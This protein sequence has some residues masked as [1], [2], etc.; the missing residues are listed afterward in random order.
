MLP[1]PMDIRLRTHD[2]T[3]ALHLLGLRYEPGGHAFIGIFVFKSNGYGAKLA[4]WMHV[5]EIRKLID[6]LRAMDTL[7]QGH[8]EL[9]PAGD[10]H[11]VRL[12]L[13]QRGAL[14]VTAELGVPT[15]NYLIARF[16]TDQTCLAPL[17]DDLQRLMLTVD[18]DTPR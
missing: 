2:E 8:A 10:F 1:E 15:S 13:T 12:Q 4:L 18:A 16:T 14:E 7:L 11:R 9:W 17:I 5:S 6:R 3:L